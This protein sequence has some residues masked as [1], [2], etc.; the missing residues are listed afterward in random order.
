MLIVPLWRLRPSRSGE[1]ADVTLLESGMPF[2]C[3]VATLTP[4]RSSSAARNED[5]KNT[6][7]FP[8]ERWVKAQTDPGAQMLI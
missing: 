4:Q 8:T 6:G 7:P 2:M 3:K 1:R 5:L